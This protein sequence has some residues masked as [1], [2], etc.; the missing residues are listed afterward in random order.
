MNMKIKVAISFL[1]QI[2]HIIL[3]DNSWLESTHKPINEAFNMA[4]EAL[5]LKQQ[6]LEVG[7]SGTEERIHIDGRLFAIR[8]LAQ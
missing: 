4:I 6:I 1:N 8:E 2:R 7:Y 5:E 3:L